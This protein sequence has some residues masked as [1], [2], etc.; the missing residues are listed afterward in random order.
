[1][2]DVAFETVIDWQ[3]SL[4]FALFLP[5]FTHCLP[6]LL[7]QVL[8]DRFMNLSK[9]VEV[10]RPRTPKECRTGPLFM[11]DSTLFAILSA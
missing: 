7:E 1:M 2:F 10:P 3:F 5:I 6:I 11:T 4:E 9:I 8:H